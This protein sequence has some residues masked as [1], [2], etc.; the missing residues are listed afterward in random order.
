MNFV[1]LFI[2]TVDVPLSAFFM[3]IFGFSF[4]SLIA[5]CSL[6]GRLFLGLNICIS[7]SRILTSSKY[8][9]SA[10]EQAAP[11]LILHGKDAAF[12]LYCGR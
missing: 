1:F 10:N 5:R 12:G 2:M 7:A 9:S 8:V 4:N 3:L 11:S 6:F